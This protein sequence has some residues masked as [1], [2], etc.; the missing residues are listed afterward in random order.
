MNKILIIDDEEKLRSL[1]V[2][3]I[4][5]ED[6]AFDVW[7]AGTIKKAMQLLEQHD[8]DVIVSDVKLPDGNGIDII[9]EIQK[10]QQIAETILMTAYGNIADGVQAMKNGAFDYITKGD[11]NNKLLPL[12]YKAIDKAQL[13]RRVKQ[14]E[15]QVGKQYSF[16]QIVGTSPVLLEAIDL[17]RKVASTDTTVML[18]GETGTGKEVF[19]QAIHA[20]SLRRE[21]AFVALNCAAFG[22]EILESELFGHRAGSF[23]GAM[24]DKKGLLEEAH[25]GTVFLDEIGE[26]ALDLQAKLLRVLETGEFLKIGDTQ[27]TKVDVRIISATNRNLETEVSIGHFRADLYYRLSVFEISL[28]PLRDRRTDIPLLAKFFAQQDASRL[29]KK[30]INF[31]PA[32]LQILQDNPWK[33]NIR[34]LRNTIERSMIITNGSLLDVDSLP[35]DM[36][37]RSAEIIDTGGADYAMTTMER[38]HIQQVLKHTG[39]NKAEAARLLGIG[40]A[41]LY[42]KIDEYKL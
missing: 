19:A 35:F 34:E 15:L 41:T 4:K 40:V 10:R 39:G 6:A 7:E 14:L 23:T 16:D 5:L 30:E 18:L 24:K 13:K 33:G 37:R 20:E 12:I 22:R 17:G 28:P 31:S 9:P 38:E 21:R 42:R 11:D 26:M 36:R 1:L 32:Y 29:G 25:R 2:R 27:P 3:I 8:F